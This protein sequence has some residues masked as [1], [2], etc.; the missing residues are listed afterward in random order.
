M[1]GAVGLKAQFEDAKLKVEEGERDRVADDEKE[2]K[3]AEERIKTA[4]LGT[5]T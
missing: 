1:A 5:C 3:A 4:A 2:Y